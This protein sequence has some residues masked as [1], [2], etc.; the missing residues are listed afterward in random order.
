MAAYIADNTDNEAYYVNNSFLED[1]ERHKNGKLI[2]AGI[3]NRKS[4]CTFTTKDR[5]SG[6]FLTS[7]DV[8]KRRN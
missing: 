4:A 1:Y 5:L 6:C 7:A 2:Y 8:R 3:K